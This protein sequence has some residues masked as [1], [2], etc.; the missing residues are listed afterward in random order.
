MDT[1]EFGGHN[2]RINTQSLRGLLFSPM[3]FGRL[4]CGGIRKN[5]FQR[6]LD[7]PANP[8]GASYQLLQYVLLVGIFVT[9]WG[10]MGACDLGNC[11]LVDEVDTAR[12]GL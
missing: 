2:T 3:F 4:H 12:F 6:G 11:P 5:Y 8:W 10:G 9:G 1:D 7:L